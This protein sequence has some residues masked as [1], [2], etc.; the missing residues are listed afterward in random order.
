MGVS[1]GVGDSAWVLVHKHR[2]ETARGP[3]VGYGGMTKVAAVCPLVILLVAAAPSPDESPLVI[4]G[5]EVL[6]TPTLESECL[7]AVPLAESVAFRAGKLGSGHMGGG[8]VVGRYARVT[9]EQADYVDGKIRFHVRAVMPDVPGNSIEWQGTIRGDSIEGAVSFTTVGEPTGRDEIDRA[10][11]SLWE[12]RYRPKL[13]YV[14]GKL[15]NEEVVEQ[16]FWHESTELREKLLLP[17]RV[18]VYTFAG[19]LKWTAKEDPGPRRA[20]RP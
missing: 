12:T 20:V 3:M 13:F 17:G 14:S 7:G 10:I 15:A 8:C 5:Y 1:D 9:Q 11:A 2:S 6:M 4:R 16:E 19:R 18:I